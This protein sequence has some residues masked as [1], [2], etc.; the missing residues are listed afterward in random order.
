[1]CG[2]T[3]ADKNIYGIDIGAD[4]YRVKGLEIAGAN[5]SGILVQGAH[6]FVENCVV[7]DSE[8]TGVLINS[9]SGF[10]GSGTYATLLNADSH[11]NH[12]E[13][14]DGANADGFGAKKGTGVGNVFDGCRA[15]DNADDGYDFFAW[16]SP[17]TVKNSWA[18]NQGATTAGAQSNGN[19]FKMGGD[20]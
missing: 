17:I 12:D 13:R 19:G 11:H 20:N 3:P 6:D 14:C 18:F 8:D 5:D 7:H 15:W 9:S 4:W 16:T 1:A 10:T 2:E